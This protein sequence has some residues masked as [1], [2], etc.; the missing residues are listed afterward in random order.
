MGDWEECGACA[1]S[2]G[3]KDGRRAPQVHQDGASVGVEG[4]HV[5]PRWGDGNAFDLREVLAR[6]GGAGGEVEVNLGDAIAHAR[7]EV[8]AP[9]AQVAAAVGRAQQIAEPVVR[10]GHG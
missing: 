6:Q 1:P 7:Q 2:P 5:R 8:V 10:H 3:G 4:D 9:D